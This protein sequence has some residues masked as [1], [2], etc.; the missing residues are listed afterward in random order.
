[1]T[2]HIWKPISKSV[3]GTAL[4][5]SFRAIT[6]NSSVVNRGLVEQKGIGQH[7]NQSY[8]RSVDDHGRHCTVS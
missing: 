5:N 1:M 4:N 3:L 6:C 8:S 7:E 2:T